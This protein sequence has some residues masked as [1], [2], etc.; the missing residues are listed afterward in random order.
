MIVWVLTVARYIVTG[1][2][3][4]ESGLVSGLFDGSSR[5]ER[6]KIPVV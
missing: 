2:K 1:R 6:K 4:A 3:L 5:N